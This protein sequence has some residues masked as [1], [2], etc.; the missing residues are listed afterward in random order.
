MRETIIEKLKEIEAKKQITIVHAIESGSRAWGFAS[1]DSDYD[2]RFIYIHP[3]EFYLRLG[4]TR[5]VIEHPLDA[6]LDINGWDLDKALR[7]LHGSNPTLFEW[8]NSPI[9]YHTTPIFEQ[10]KP[11]INDYFK[12]KSGLFHYLSMAGGNYRDYLK[13]DYVRAKKYFY[14]LRPLLACRWILAHKCPPPMLFADLVADQL[15]PELQPVVADLLRLK[16]EAPE[17]KEIKKIDVLNQFIEENLMV[18][19]EQINA[20]PGEKS[21]NWDDLNAFF[22]QALKETSL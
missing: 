7:L 2:V 9:I 21:K 1:L 19:K 17:Q 6:V 10:L 13:G 20:L 4:K 18:L 8:C 11:L 16:M 3:A 12:A 14:V 15:E 22:L 5:D